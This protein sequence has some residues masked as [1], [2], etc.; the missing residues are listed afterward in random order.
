VRSTAIRPVRTA[1]RSPWQ[2]GVAE[3]WIESCRRDLLD[4]VIALHERHLRRLLS[5]YI[6]YYHEDR[7]HLGLNKETPAGRARSRDRGAVVSRAR[8]AASST[9]TIELR[10]LQVA[11]F[12]TGSLPEVQRSVGEPCFRRTKS[13]GVVAWDIRTRA[14]SSGKE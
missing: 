5:D 1:V 11:G 10:N 6:C 8:L 14:D 4:Q 7:T 9:A 2:N 13:H 3:R 12:A